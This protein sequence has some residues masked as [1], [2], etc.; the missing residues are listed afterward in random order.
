[1]HTFNMT[2]LDSRGGEFG[3]MCTIEAIPGETDKE[4]EDENESFNH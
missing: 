3:S 2:L 1:M 4:K